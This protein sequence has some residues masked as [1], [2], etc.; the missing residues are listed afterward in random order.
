MMTTFAEFSDGVH[1]GHK[2]RAI[3]KLRAELTDT[4]PLRRIENDLKEE[5][6]N[7]IDQQVID[8]S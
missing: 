3:S 1:N 8:M 2:L 6:F 7:Y 4:H 5:L